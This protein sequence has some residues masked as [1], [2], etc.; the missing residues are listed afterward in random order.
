M[1]TA[2]EYCRLQSAAAAAA[3]GRRSA[4]EA[5]EGSLYRIGRTNGARGRAGNRAGGRTAPADAEREG[6]GTGGA[7]QD[8]WRLQSLWRW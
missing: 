3:A 6:V 8:V 7:L 5:C 1:A 4:L 2:A